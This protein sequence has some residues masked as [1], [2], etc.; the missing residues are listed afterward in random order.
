MLEIEALR[1]DAS[2][3]LTDSCALGNARRLHCNL[4]HAIVQ[5]RSF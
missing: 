5:E 3:M 4:G 1:S 2:G